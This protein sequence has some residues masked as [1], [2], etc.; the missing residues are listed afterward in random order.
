VIGRAPRAWPLVR[1][2]EALTKA[3]LEIDLY[4]GVQSRERALYLVALSGAEQQD[5][6]WQGLI[7]PN[8]EVREPRSGTFAI[9]PVIVGRLC[10]EQ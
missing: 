8:A 1:L 6:G 3:I 10:I 4:F 5:L 2:K 9:G 7:V